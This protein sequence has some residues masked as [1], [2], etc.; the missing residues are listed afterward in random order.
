MEDKCH[1]CDTNFPNLELHFHDCHSEDF[2]HIFNET[3]NDS[4]ANQKTK[5]NDIKSE[6][7]EPGINSYNSIQGIQGVCEF[8]IVL[9]TTMKSSHTPWI[10]CINERI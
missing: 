9:I 6:L 5:Q 7:H 10:P 8:F 4:N 1:I 3:D 2:S